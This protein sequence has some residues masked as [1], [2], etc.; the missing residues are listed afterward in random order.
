V[1]I[2]KLFRERASLWGDATLSTFDDAGTE[3]VVVPRPTALT[4][5]LTVDTATVGEQRFRLRRRS[6][7]SDL[8]SAGALLQFS[9]PELLDDMVAQVEGF[10]RRFQRR[11]TEVRLECCDRVSCPKLHKDNVYARAVIT[12]AG[13]GTQYARADHPDDLHDTATGALVLLKGVR[14]PTDAG[15]WLHRSPPLEPGQRRLCLVIDC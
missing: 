9:S 13:P 2:I 4:V 10:A 15:L 6:L 1:S 8:R 3:V 12:Y 7:V 5:P 11:S 14:H